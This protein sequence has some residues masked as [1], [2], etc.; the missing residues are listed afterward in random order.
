MLNVTRL[1]AAVEGPA[2]AAAP[3]GVTPPQVVVWNLTRSCNLA[4]RQCYAAARARPDPDELT[5]SE[6]L[7]LIADLA[8]AGVR[9]LVLS[10]G[11]P[12]LRADLP[13]LAASAAAHGLAVA[14]STNGT[15]LRGAMARTLARAGVTYVGVSLDGIGPRHDRV[16][17]RPG[18]W[19]EA[20]AGLRAARDAGL[21]VGVRFTLCRPTLDQ[22]PAVLDL[23]EA[24]D[25]DRGYVS[26]LVQV[27]RARRWHPAALGPAEVRAAV[28]RV[29]DRAE[30]WRRR[31]RRTELVTGN[32]D[33]DGVALYLRLAAREP[34]RAARL[35]SLLQARGGNAAGRAIAAVDARGDVH[36][37]P[38]WTTARLG[39][40]RDRP[41]SAVWLDAAQP[42]LRALRDRTGRLTGRCRVC[43]YLAACGGGSRARAEALT[44]DPWA[45]DPACYLTDAELGLNRGRIPHAPLASAR[46]E[47]VDPVVP[48]ECAL[49]GPCRR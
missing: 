30:A 41:F 46:G 37:E 6:G 23:M 38:F 21:R 43:P 48:G 22:L 28:E 3:T 15:L 26:H 40:V 36:P 20:L 7:A 42:L 24:E 47:R 45:A 17:G 4:C 39:N 14:L 5:T 11:E 12:L 10:G 44:G 16:R 1:L 34:V 9:A 29:F 33:A 27:G 32:N 49:P 2:A 19:V 31:S 8:R 18:A 35:L 25:V 13:A